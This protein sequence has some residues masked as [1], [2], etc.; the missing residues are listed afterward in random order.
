[1]KLNLIT[2]VPVYNGERFIVQTLESVARQTTR[3]DRLIVLDNCSTDG[4]ERLV[5]EFKAMPCEFIR[6]PKTSACSAT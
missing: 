4:T 2:V 5:R 6:N 1:M 3:P